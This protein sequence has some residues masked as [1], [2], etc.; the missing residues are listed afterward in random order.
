MQSI[1]NILRFNFKSPHKEITAIAKE[2]ETLKVWPDVFAKFCPE[3]AE[4]SMALSFKGGVL[5]IA[6]LDDSTADAVQFCRDRLMEEMN[7]R[8]GR[9][10][11]YWIACER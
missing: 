10:M 4:R 8:L 5:T 9:R 7:Q 11:V 6:A 1:G 2:T 3:Y